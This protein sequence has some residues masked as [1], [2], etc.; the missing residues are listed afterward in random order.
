MAGG[1]EGQEVLDIHCSRAAAIWKERAEDI[2]ENMQKLDRKSVQT[3][4]DS[5]RD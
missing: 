3:G 1:V 4:S 2:V 5:R